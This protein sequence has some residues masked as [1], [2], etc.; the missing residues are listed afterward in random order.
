MARW[1]L[2][3]E[4]R[5]YNEFFGNCTGES[6]KKDW[7]EGHRVAEREA[8]EEKDEARSFIRI[9]GFRMTNDGLAHAGYY[10]GY[11]VGL[12]GCAGPLFGGGY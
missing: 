10:Y 12:F 2:S 9:R 5:K 1:L 4:W 6:A 11:V 8:R 3:L 7:L